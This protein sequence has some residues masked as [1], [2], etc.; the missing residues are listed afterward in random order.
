MIR[1][2]S[3]CNLI[4]LTFEKLLI[5]EENPKNSGNSKFR[6]ATTVC[7]ITRILNLL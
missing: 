4:E 5:S 6:V 7:I 1:P 3:D 2:K